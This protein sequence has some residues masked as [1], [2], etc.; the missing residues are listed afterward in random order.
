ME[1]NKDFIFY[2]LPSGSAFNEYIRDNNV[3]HYT[4]KDFEPIVDVALKENLITESNIYSIKE[5]LKRLLGE[6]NKHEYIEK[7]D[8]IYESHMGGRLIFDLYN[9]NFIP[10]IK[11]SDEEAKVQSTIDINNLPMK[12][13]YTSK[14]LKKLKKS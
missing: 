11:K 8:R 10:R 4:K 6:A 9:F 13:I 5:E 2:L 14:E 1:Y 7:L 12:D 3:E